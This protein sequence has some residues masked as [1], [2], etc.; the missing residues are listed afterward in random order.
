M[1]KYEKSREWGYFGTRREA[2]ATLRS[3]GELLCAG[4]SPCGFE[5]L[6]DEALRTEH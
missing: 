3:L 6:F 1:L 4:F 2:P 5:M